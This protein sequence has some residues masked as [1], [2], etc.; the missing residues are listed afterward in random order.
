MRYR[1][2]GRTELK[3]SELVFGGGW[4]GGVLIHQDDATKLKVLRHA[5]DAGVN[6]IDTATKYGD[7]KSEEALG[8]LLPELDTKP[9]VSTKVMLDTSRLDD[10]AG[11]VERSVQGSLERLKLPH[12]DLLQL[13]NPLGTR[14]VDPSASGNAISAGDV[15]AAGGVAEAL[16]RMR[17]QGLTK[18]IGFTALGDTASCREVI[19]SGRFDSAQIYYNMLNPSAARAMPQRWVGQ[20]FAN[21][22]SACKQQNMASMVIRVFAAGLL[23][24]DERHGREVVIARDAELAVEAQRAAAVFAELG[25]EYGD[26]A[27]TALRFVLSNPDISCAVFGLA[28]LSHLQTALDAESAGALPQAALERIETVYARNF[29]L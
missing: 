25:K 4:V 7:G 18:F 5:V 13:H 24:S 8:W 26:R 16:E 27:Q 20:D 12:V 3:V 11:Q 23:A 22:V 14:A 9:Y 17:E 1:T 2:F 6:W 15:L 21:L 19:D 28:Q 10:I 29:G